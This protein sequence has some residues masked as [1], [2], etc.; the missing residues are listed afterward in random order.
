MYRVHVLCSFA[1]AVKLAWLPADAA[2]VACPWSLAGDEA[3]VPTFN[4]S[5]ASSSWASPNV[6]HHKTVTWNMSRPGE[7]QHQS[8]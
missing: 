7:C 1:V 4:G 8:L 3:G 2:Q 6:P 5:W